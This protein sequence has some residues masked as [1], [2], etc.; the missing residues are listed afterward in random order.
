FWFTA[1]VVE[2]DHSRRATVAFRLGKL[3]YREGAYLSIGISQSHLD[4]LV[5]GFVFTQA[6]NYFQ[7]GRGLAGLALGQAGSG[8]PGGHQYPSGDCDEHSRRNHV[9]PLARRGAHSI[10]R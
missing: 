10:V 3:S 7:V 2:F 6:L 1:L 4:Q 8:W 9:P 5:K